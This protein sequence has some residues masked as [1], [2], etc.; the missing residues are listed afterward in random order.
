MFPA[1]STLN[2]FL[3]KLM[4]QN[5]KRKYIGIFKKKVAKLRKRIDVSSSS[6]E[7]AQQSSESDSNKESSSS[8]SIK[9]ETVHRDD[10]E[11]T[12]DDFTLPKN[13]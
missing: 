10:S 1:I 5:L 2:P 3:L 9:E 8:S 13:S 12:P 6:E 4:R 7:S 11:D